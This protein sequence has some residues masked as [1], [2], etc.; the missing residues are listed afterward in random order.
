MMMN[1][2]ESTTNLFEEDETRPSMVQKQRVSFPLFFVFPLIFYIF[3]VLQWESNRTTKSLGNRQSSV[4]FAIPIVP[5]HAPQD[6]AQ[7]KTQ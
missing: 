7:Q 2:V 4:S 1:S 6:S 3:T 5:Y